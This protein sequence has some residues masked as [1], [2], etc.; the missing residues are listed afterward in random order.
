MRWKSKVT[1]VRAL[2]ARLAA[3]SSTHPQEMEKLEAVEKQGCAGWIFT[4][5]ELGVG[6]SPTKG[7]KDC[8]MQA[9]LIGRALVL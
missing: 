8:F 9:Q 4:W 1:A 6:S 5:L 3:P 7:G 2:S